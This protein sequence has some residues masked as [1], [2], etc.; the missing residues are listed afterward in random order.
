M[1]CSC[2]LIEN[3]RVNH[4][5]A[6]LQSMLTKKMRRIEFECTIHVAHIDSE[7]HSYQYF[8]APRVAVAHPGI[9]TVHTIPQ[10]SIIFFKQRKEAR[11]VMDIKLPIRVHEKSQV[12]ANRVK[13]ADY[14]RT[15]SLVD[16]VMY[17]FETWM[18]GS[19][20][21]KDDAGSI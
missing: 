8:P 14:G 3:L 17:N 18:S 9:L 1:S 20:C 16:G 2:K 10:D 12:F 19:N 15:I 11:Q 5:P 6:S 13:A 4:G 7:D 21:I